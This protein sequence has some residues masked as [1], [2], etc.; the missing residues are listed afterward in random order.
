[1]IATSFQN[2]NPLSGHE[3]S[4]KTYQDLG[5]NDTEIDIFNQLHVD[6]VQNTIDF[7]NNTGVCKIHFMK[8]EF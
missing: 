6:N 7:I 4:R 5:M 8:N 2:S 3:V 1:M